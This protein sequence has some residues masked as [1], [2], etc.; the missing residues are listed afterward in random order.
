MPFQ[1]KVAILLVS[2]RHRNIDENSGNHETAEVIMEHL[3]EIIRLDIS[4]GLGCKE[5]T[6]FTFLTLGRDE[7][8]YGFMLW[9]L[10]TLESQ[11]ISNTK[12]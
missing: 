4:D 10:K 7:D 1:R 3:L 9:W 12:S 5:M 6:V 2:S 11:W 8:A